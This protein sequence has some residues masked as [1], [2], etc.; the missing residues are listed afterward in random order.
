MYERIY[1]ALQRV[2]REQ[3]ITT[4][5]DIAPLAGL[6]MRRPNDRKKL[7]AILGAIAVFE[8]Q[9]GRPLLPVV[10]VSREDNRPGKGFFTL[11]RELGLLEGDDEATELAFFCQEVAKVHATW[12]A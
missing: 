12:R 6:D 3:R 1:E 7:T 4:Y 10:V 11:A 2:A 9:Q 8:H 5:K